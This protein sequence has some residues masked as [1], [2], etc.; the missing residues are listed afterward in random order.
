MPG[1]SFSNF[2][3]FEAIR[4]DETLRVLGEHLECVELHTAAAVAGLMLIALG[5]GE[6]PVSRRCAVLRSLTGRLGLTS[7]DG[8]SRTF[9]RDLVMLDE[10]VSESGILRPLNAFGVYRKR[11]TPAEPRRAG[12]DTVRS[13]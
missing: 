8:I 2:S 10:L 13:S 5:P 9:V 7:R 11:G 4:S 6:H 1:G 3:P 12:A